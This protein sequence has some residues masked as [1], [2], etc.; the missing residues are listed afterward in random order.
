VPASNPIWC[1]PGAGRVLAGG[2]VGT[3]VAAF[4]GGGYLR[5]PGGYVLLAPAGSPRGPLSLLVRGLR[6]PRARAP[7]TVWGEAATLTI[8]GAVISLAE[9]EQ[10]RSPAPP[11]RIEA[12]AR[13]AMR[14][15]LAAVAPAPAALRPG[16]LALARGS[17]SDG[18]R[19]LAGL[20]DGLTP[21]GDDALAGWAAW[22]WAAGAPV[23][24]GE[25]AAERCSPIGLAYLE[26]AV[27][28]ELPRFAG[29]LLAA[30]AAGDAACAV[31]QSG[32]AGTW[33]GSSGAALVWGL[34]AG[35]A[36]PAVGAAG[37]KTEPLVRFDAQEHVVEAA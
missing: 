36:V 15:A 2:G 7:V 34:A 29:A 33:G 3:V 25:F 26:C 5:L 13:P 8:G 17:W 31:A 12:A 30:I 24:V 23:A 21:A 4:G 22:R 18:V 10:P 6:A 35:V 37:H 14:A 28:G 9:V 1:G 11:A 16:L 19:A 32:R 20:G 27:R